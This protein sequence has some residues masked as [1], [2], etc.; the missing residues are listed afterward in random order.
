MTPIVRA[1]APSPHGGWS[2]TS[3]TS[4]RRARRS[5]RSCEGRWRMPEPDARPATRLT[6]GALRRSVP[7]LLACA[8]LGGGLALALDDS[9]PGYRASAEVIVSPLPEQDVSLLGLSLL[10]YSR[11]SARAIETAAVLLHSPAAAE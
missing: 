9:Q 1:S 6:L 11:E 5:P 4:A 3:T 7:V 8:V 10:R 2:S